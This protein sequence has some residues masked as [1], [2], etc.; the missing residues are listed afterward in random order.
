MN[1]NLN[2]KIKQD[3]ENIADDA[4]EL[5]KATAS[6][7]GERIEKVRARAQDSLRA[8]RVRLTDARTSVDEN[9]RA[10]AGSIDDQVHDHPYAAAGI[11]AG[12]G[13]LIGLL[14]GRS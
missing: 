13:L 8:A 10:T 14:I 2:Q 3:L 5:L 4:E 1:A 6:Q 12:I 11:A 9:V 7:T